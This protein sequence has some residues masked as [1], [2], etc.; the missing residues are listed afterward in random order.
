MKK[1]K[2]IFLLLSLVWLTAYCA[3]GSSSG[4]GSSTNPGTSTPAPTTYNNADLKGNWRWSANRQTD[5]LN[6][7]GTL[8][9]NENLRV[10][11][12]E[13]DR[14]PGRQDFSTAQ[15]W[16]WS[17]GFVKGNNQAFCDYP[18]TEVKFAMDFDPGSGKKRIS[19]LMDIHDGSSGT[20]VYNRF[21][22]TMTKQ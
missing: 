5:G 20:D 16:L 12:W 4:G 22:I 8:S 6:L 21:D 1:I 18:K 2:P 14:C 7:T 3:G 13:T 11:G 19:G 9:F 15:F 10:I 17:N